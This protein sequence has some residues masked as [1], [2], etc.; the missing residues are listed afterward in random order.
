M[1][2]IQIPFNFI[3]SKGMTFFFLPWVVA[4]KKRRQTPT[5]DPLR[6]F[7]S[8]LRWLLAEIHFNEPDIINTT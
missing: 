4:P 8:R 2:T 3:C 1:Y 5:T 7:K 6:R